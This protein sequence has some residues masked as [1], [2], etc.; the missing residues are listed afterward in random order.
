[1]TDL[2]NKEELPL[3]FPEPKP[4]GA[5]EEI[6]Q[7][8]QLHFYIS[9]AIEEPEKY[10]EMIHAIRAASPHDVV[11]IHLN[12]PGGH[13]DTGIQIINAMRQSE[14]LVVTHLEGEVCSMGA[15]IFL[16]G[17]EMVPYEYC[18]L[19]FHNYSGGVFFKGHEQEAALVA[20]QALYGQLIDDICHPFLTKGEIKKI[21][22][23]QDIWLQRDGII[24]RLEKVQK[25]AEKEMAE[26]E[27]AMEEAGELS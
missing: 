26:M 23:G 19:M 17:N 22:D 14:G 11:H 3:L 20:N 8:R 12:T 2:F 9:Q 21:K 25:A 27:A 6:I 7:V 16:A 15:L 4:Y 10:H 1:M 5:Y 24:K 18:M 13:L